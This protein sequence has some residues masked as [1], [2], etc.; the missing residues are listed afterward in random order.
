MTLALTTPS[1]CGLRVIIQIFAYRRHCLPRLRCWSLIFDFFP[2]CRWCVCTAGGFILLVLLH[3]HE[4]HLDHS[5]SPGHVVL[6]WAYQQAS[7][8]CQ[9]TEEVS[10]TPPNDGQTNV[11][12]LG[13]QHTEQ[14][15]DRYSSTAI[16]IISTAGCF[17]QL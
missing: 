4:L 14:L 13:E 12:D 3:H 2:F 9:F 17:S 6:S 5:A 11:L 15:Y 10:V 8:T 1:D 7:G 16:T